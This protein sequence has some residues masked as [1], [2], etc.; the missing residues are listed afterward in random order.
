MVSI[1]HDLYLVKKFLDFI[2]NETII[3]SM[4][5]I[6]IIIFLMT[7]ICAQCEACYYSEPEQIEIT[8]PEGI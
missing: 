1:K 2:Q 4:K 6:I 3:G 5:S 7:A 8:M